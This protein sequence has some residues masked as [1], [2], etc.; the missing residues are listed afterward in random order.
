[1]LD[2][3]RAVVHEALVDAFISLDRIEDAKAAYAQSIARGF[4]GQDMQEKRYIIAFLEKDAITMQ[5]LAAASA[6]QRSENVFLALDAGAAAYAGRLREAEDLMRRA[7]E[8]ARRDSQSNLAATWLGWEAL[9]E[10]EYGRADQ[11]KASAQG[12]LKTAKTR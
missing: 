8:T 10:A 2:P 1:R 3:N 7:V 11:A 4:N 6:G 5:H 12:A 9:A